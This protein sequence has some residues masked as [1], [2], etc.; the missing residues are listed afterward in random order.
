MKETVNRNY[1]E[2]NNLGFLFDVDQEALGNEHS[3][4]IGLNIGKIL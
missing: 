1:I 3:T 2:Q 4:L